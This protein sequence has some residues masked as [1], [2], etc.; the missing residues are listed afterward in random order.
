MWWIAWWLAV[1]T[2]GTIGTIAATN[3]LRFAHRIGR[4]VQE[5]FASS[6]AS[7]APTGQRMDRVPPPVRRYLTKVLGAR[8]V[9]IRTVRLR[10]GGSFRPSLNGAWLPIAGEQYFTS[11]PPGFIW[12]GR[13]RMAPGLW[14]DAR[15][16]SVQGVGNMLVKAESTV[17]LADSRGA[18]L[19]QGALL[20]LLGEMPWFPTAFLDDRYVRWSAVDEH[21]ARA[22][23]Q[24]SGRAVTGE[25]EFGADDLPVTF[26]ADRY[27]DVGSGRTLLTP[28]VG[29]ISDYRF[30]KDVIVPH[31]VVGAWLI[32]GQTAEYARFEVAELALDSERAY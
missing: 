21:R 10:H 3:S 20:R 8:S 15:D 26:S 14:I 19:D 18:Q 7:A 2:V 30:V 4:E 1:T 11:D 17:T 12:W 5:L 25:F 22:T 16:R 6:S 29:R 32:D 31:R 28:F 9:A 24:V 27:R 13:V 23:L